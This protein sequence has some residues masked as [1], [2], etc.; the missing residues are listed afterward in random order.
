MFQSSWDKPLC[1]KKLDWLLINTPND[2]EK[3]RILAVSCEGASAF[4][5]ALP[6]AN[7]GLRLTDIELPIVC[8]LR[9]GST[10]CKPR[11]C[12]CGKSVE[13]NGRHRLS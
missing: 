7:C 12:F 6:L 9:I 8:S 4:L 2:T 11:I 1:K 5:N 10:L 3:A 13:S